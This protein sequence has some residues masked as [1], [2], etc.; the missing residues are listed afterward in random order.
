MS[1]YEIILWM[2]RYVQEPSPSPS[3]YPSPS[4]Q[5]RHSHHKCGTASRRVFCESM[6]SWMSSMRQVCVCVN[7]GMSESVRVCVI[8]CV[9]EMERSVLSG[10]LSPSFLMRSSLQS[11]ENGHLT[12]IV[13]AFQLE[14]NH[15]LRQ[16]YARL[17][18]IAFTHSINAVIRAFIQHTQ[19][20]THTHIC[21]GNCVCQCV[22]VSRHVYISVCSS[23]IYVCM[24]VLFVCVCVFPLDSICVHYCV[25]VCVCVSVCQC[26]TACIIYLS[27]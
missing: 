16:S 10:V 2:S 18:S 24:C 26:V 5:R 12:T 6:S 1:S 15:T 21:M 13:N 8:E 22:I 4:L 27:V 9:L 14:H 19:V 23:I 25:C 11:P 20:C 17:A 3:P 7:N